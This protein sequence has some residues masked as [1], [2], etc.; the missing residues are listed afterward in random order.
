MSFTS[1]ERYKQSGVE[2]LGAVPEHWSTLPLLAVGRERDE[3]NTGMAESNL[4]SLSYG[5]IIRK[6]INTNEGLLP[7]SFETYQIVHPGDIIFRL[8]DLQNDKRSLRTA[9]VEERGIITSAYLA[10][11]PLSANPQFLN[12]LFRAYDLR[13][14][15]Y[16]MGGGVRQSMNYEDVKRMEMLLPPMDEQFAI[17]GFLDLE[18]TKIDALIQEQRRLIVLLKEKRQ[19]VIS[20]TVTKGLN[21]CAPMKDP[22]IEWI[23]Q[24]P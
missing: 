13:K 18:T 3:R 22:G 14:V 2:W 19:A 17:A 15:F 12:Y 6:D 4:L 24:L 21:P 20:H 1:Y 7:E 9:I 23:G 8:T 11:K 10:L 5:R 16:A